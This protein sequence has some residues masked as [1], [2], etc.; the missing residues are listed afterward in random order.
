V[1]VQA[2]VIIFAEP[3]ESWQ[4]RRMIGH[5]YNAVEGGLFSFILAM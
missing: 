3:W 2:R 1:P 4:V 5:G